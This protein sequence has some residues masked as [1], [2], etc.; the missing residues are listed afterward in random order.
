M[1]QHRKHTILHLSIPAIIGVIALTLSM[2]ARAQEESSSS[3]PSGLGSIEIEQNNSA[4]EKQIGKWTLLL[5]GGE[6]QSNS[7]PTKTLPSV[8]AG[9]YTIIINLPEGTSN[10]IRIYRN[11]VMENLVQRPQATFTLQQGERV[12]VVI[13]YVFS[14]VGTVTVDSDPVGMTFRIQ[15]PNSLVLKG[16]TPT[17]FDNQ[18]EGQY[19]IL[20]D[21]LE[22]CVKPPAKSA[23]LEV[24]NRINFSVR[25]V[26][27]TANQIREENAA[28]YANDENFVTVR[29]E[30]GNIVLHDV[31]LDAWFATAVANAAKY[32]ILT[33][34]RDESGKPTGQFGP[35]N[36]VTVAE[37]AKIAHK[38]SGTSE[39]AFNAQPP[40]NIFAQNMWFSPF[41]ASAESRGWTIFS[42]AT[43]D[44]TRPATRGE[45]LITLLQ[46]LDVPLRWQ[47][48]TIFADVTAR[49]PYAA[50]IETAAADKIVEGRDDENG[51]GAKTFGPTDAINRAEMAKIIGKVLET[52]RSATTSN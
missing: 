35:G 7:N 13:N 33:G 36:D 10:S 4:D 32:G 22:G 6:Q 28:Q 5:P 8:P 42:D 23:K 41:I 40:E 52:Y 37:L 3:A 46:V 26:C 9:S 27:D 12:K 17:S 44:P 1:V 31:P 34:Y 50:A 24:G 19:K 43:I 25:I 47:K 49:S 11:D 18:P 21:A 2:I 29:G 39:A 51:T 16:T 20:Y 14:R 15:G 30:N 38:L 48:G 45:V